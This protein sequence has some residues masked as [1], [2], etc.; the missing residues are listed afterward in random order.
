MGEDGQGQRAYPPSRRDLLAAL[1]ALPLPSLPFVIAD[2][3]AD[4]SAA[5]RGRRPG[6]GD[7]PPVSALAVLALLRALERDSLVKGYSAQQWAD[8]GTEVGGVE[9]SVL[10]TLRDAQLGGWAAQ[11]PESWAALGLDPDESAHLTRL[12]WSVDNWRD[13]QAA[14]IRRTLAVDRLTAAVRAAEAARR[15]SPVRDAVDAVLAERE[16]LYKSRGP[17][18]GP[19]GW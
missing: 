7:P 13:A 19:Q 12:W 3:I 5:R 10:D 2:R 11:K 1:K 8:L 15:Y 4:A 14:G 18:D 17:F 9:L 6:P 16:R